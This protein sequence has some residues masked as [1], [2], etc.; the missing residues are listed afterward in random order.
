MDMRRLFL[1]ATFGFVFYFLLQAWQH[2]YP[3][4]TPLVKETSPSGLPDAGL[5]DHLAEL[6]SKSA[7]AVATQFTPST[8]TIDV[9]TDVVH[10]KIDLNQGEIVQADLMQYPVS[11]KDKSPIQLLSVSPTHQFIAKSQLVSPGEQ[12]LDVGQ[13]N[14]KA[15]SSSYELTPGQDQLVIHLEGENKDGLKVTKTYTL[16]RGAYLV[17]VAYSISNQGNTPWTGYLNTQLVQ[18][19]PPENTSS[20]FQIGTYSGASYSEPGVHRYQKVPFQ[21][22][23]KANLDLKVKGGWIAMQQ[24]YFLVSWVPNADFTNQFYTRAVDNSYMIG[25]LSDAILLQPGDTKSLQVR[26]YAGPENT[27]VLR[28]ISPGLDL[29]VDYGWFWFISGILFSVMK[30]IYDVIGNWGW[31]IIIV[32]LL[33]KLAF[34]RLSASSYRSMAGMRQ[35]QP[36][37]QALKERFGEDKA[38]LSQAT[39]ELYRKEKINPFGGCL[40]ILIQIPVF[41]ALYW[42]LI[43][44]VE[45]RQA[46]FIFWI[47]DLA[48]PDAYHVLP[49]IMG[50]TM[51]VQQ[52]LN[53][54]PPDPMQAKMMMMLPLLFTGIFWNFPAGL[55]LYWIVNNVLS[56]LQQW[57]ITRRL[58][59]ATV[60]SK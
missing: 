58:E 10:F 35:I 6:K 17:D 38:K 37:L 36:K 44:S 30:W 12:G 48:A 21:D 52:R 54:A 59:K 32:T 55:V 13:F 33:I 57:W 5:Q 29:T 41:I 28:A 50:L 3:T 16:K 11:L 40:P 19:S 60:K 45:L 7:K 31:S 39:M 34:Y 51:L 8:A 42:V 14:F 15:A 23:S 56:I 24:H 43:E 9:K 4:L 27:S 25:T 1:Y 26:L 20:M 47:N 22:M 2:D 53:P 49:I 46:P 18:V